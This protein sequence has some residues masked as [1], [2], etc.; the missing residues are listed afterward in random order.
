MGLDYQYF[1]YKYGF[2]FY[3]VSRMGS[4]PLHKEKQANRF[5]YNKS[6]PQDI[7]NKF[8]W[9][10]NQ[11]IDN[12][13]RSMLFGVPIWSM[14]QIL[15]LWTFSN[16][17]IPWIN[18]SE[19]KIW[20]ILM[21]LVVPVIHDFHFYCIHRLIHIPILYKWVHSVHHKSVNPKPIQLYSISSK[22]YS[23]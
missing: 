6:F 2:G 11:T 15:M 5:K 13:A 18:F 17:Y 8:F 23:S 3:L 9:F 20:F 19:N 21:I 10:K 7:K 12:M 22:S 16:G 14:L 1:S 4:S